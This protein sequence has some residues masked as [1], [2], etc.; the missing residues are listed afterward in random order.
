MTS[1]E[2]APESFGS[3]SGTQLPNARLRLLDEDQWQQLRDVRLTALSQSPN[4]FLSSYNAEIVYSEEQWRSEFHRGEWIVVVDE[5]ELPIA[6]IGVTES[7]DIPPADRYL[8]YLWVSPEKR[9]FKLATGLIRA[10]LKP[11]E[12]SGAGAV[13]LW[14]LDGNVPARELYNG[15]GFITTGYRHRPRANPSLWEERMILRLKPEH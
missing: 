1:S 3:L 4:S 15:C 13:W 7:D 9:R 12:A 14:I 11:L 5:T 8:E 6:L 10:V 2:G